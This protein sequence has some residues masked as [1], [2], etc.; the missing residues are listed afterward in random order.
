MKKLP[1]LSCLF[2]ILTLAVSCNKSNEGEWINL[3]NGNDLSGW[4]AIQNPD[5]FKVE[6]GM[7]VAHGGLSHLY[8]TGSQ[9]KGVFN[10]FE[11]KAMVLTKPETNSGIYVHTQTQEYGYLLKGFEIQVN[12]T[13][14]GTEENPEMRRTGSMVG[15]RNIFYQ[16]AKDDEWFEMNIKVVEN[17][18]EIRVN[19]T[20]VVDYIQPDDPYRAKNDTYRLF[21]AGLIALQ[22]HDAEG[23]TYFKDIQ[24]K[25]LPAG[26]KLAPYTDKEWDTQIS[27]LHSLQFPIVDYHV[28]LKGGLTIEEAI[29]NSMQLGI[30]YGIAPNCGLTFP[31]TDDESLFAYMDT[32]KSKPI[33]R[34]MQAEGREWVTLFSP[35]A[36]AEFD[37]IF[38]DAMTW[39][40]H[41]G[42][43]M[44]LWMPDEVYMDDEQVFMDELVS[45]IEAVISQEPVDIHVNPTFLPDVI[46]DKYDELW[47]DERIE[48]FVKVLA[49]N[50]V[51][52]EINSRYK[53]P[54]EKILRK[55][56]EAGIKFTFGTNNTGSDLGRL[57]YSIEM[58]D[59]LGLTLKDMFFPKR[60]GEKPIQLK[61]LPEKITG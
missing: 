26:E 5:A 52:L 40:D 10:N 14:N 48:R 21:D 7:I 31:V 44:R 49:E 41:D 28:H 36:I 13:Y 9:N 32:V 30:N 33:F 15:I 53:L 11:F 39:T 25:E 60:D 24:I 43:R 29:E 45:K 12:N 34:G 38:T 27:K 8:Y 61:G 42:H 6:N 17:H 23:T 54:S 22:C 59:K 56:K 19:G 1:L 50:N 35:E 51:A 47:T 57:D 18:I 46:A 20:K 2:I 16:T 58:I 37:Y 4:E 55:A 3:F